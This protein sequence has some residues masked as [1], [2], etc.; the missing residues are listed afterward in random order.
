ME[1]NNYQKNFFEHLAYIQEH[2]VQTALCNYKDSDN[3]ENLLNIVTSDV[4][5]NIM[6]MID[7]YSDFNSGKMDIIDCETGIRVKESPFIELHDC[8]GAFINE[9][10]Y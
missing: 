5:I 2:C 6:E 7:G 8:V 10:E 4:I 3:I 9:G 1:L